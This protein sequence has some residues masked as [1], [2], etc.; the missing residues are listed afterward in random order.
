MSQVVPA[1]TTAGTAGTITVI[2]EPGLNK[3]RESESFTERVMILQIKIYQSCFV[4]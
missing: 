1:G 2:W 4:L 3:L